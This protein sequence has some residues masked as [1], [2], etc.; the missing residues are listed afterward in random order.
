M[1]DT[2]QHPVG[3]LAPVSRRVMN[4]AHFLTQAARRYPEAPAL[5]MGDRTLPGARWIS[6]SVH[7]RWGCGR[8][9]WKRVTACWCRAVT[10]SR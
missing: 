2:R 10:A 9:G 7:W 4:L 8:M 1:S 5:V 3:G 6:V